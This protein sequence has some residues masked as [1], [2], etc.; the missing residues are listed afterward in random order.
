MHIIALNTDGNRSCV[1][2]L[3]FQL[4]DTTTINGISPLRTE[5]FQIHILRATADFFIRR[6]GNADITVRNITVFQT[7][8]SSDDFCDT[9]FII[10]SQQGFTVGHNQ[11]FT[12]HGVQHREHDRRQHFVTDAECDITTTVIFQNLRIHITPGEIR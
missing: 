2:V 8:H 6:E 10:R 9:G 3:I 12:Q 1:K 11:G 4:T 7:H 5:F